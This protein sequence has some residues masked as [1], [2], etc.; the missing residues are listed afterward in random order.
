MYKVQFHSI[1]SKEI[2]KSYNQIIITL[3]NIIT[4]LSF[5]I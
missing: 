1:N 4:K 2:N 3:K 5:I